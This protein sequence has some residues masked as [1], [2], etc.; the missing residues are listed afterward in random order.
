[1]EIWVDLQAK[2]GLETHLLTIFLPTL[3]LYGVLLGLA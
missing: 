2:R 3:P 1:M